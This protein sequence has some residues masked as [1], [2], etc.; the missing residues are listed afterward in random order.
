MALLPTSEA[1]SVVMSS[2]SDADGATDLSDTES[3]G[4]A[5]LPAR[6]SLQVIHD[7]YFLCR[8]IVQLSEETASVKVNRNI[9]SDIRHGLEQ[10]IW[11]DGVLR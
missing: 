10:D 8:A 7:K 5:G 11:R 4:T 3:Q 1:S 9:R 2:R 6:T